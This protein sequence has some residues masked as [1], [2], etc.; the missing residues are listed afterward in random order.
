MVIM[1]KTNWSDVANKLEACLTDISTWMNANMLKLNEEKTEVVEN[2][3]L[4][5][6]M[7]VCDH[8][9]GQGIRAR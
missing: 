7:C 3:E 1:P 5:L 6:Y 2:M 8:H 9:S 4:R